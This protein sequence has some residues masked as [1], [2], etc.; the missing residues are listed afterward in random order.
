[1]HAAE[2]G[3]GGLREADQEQLTRLL[4]GLRVAAGDFAEP[5]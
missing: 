4:R 3:L 2:F 5:A 1:M